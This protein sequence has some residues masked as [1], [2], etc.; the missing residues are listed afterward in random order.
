LLANFVA[1]RAVKDQMEDSSVISTPVDTEPEPKVV[2]VPKAKDA[3]PKPSP[4]SLKKRVEKE[5]FAA[6]F[7]ANQVVIDFFADTE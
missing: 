2:D 3:Q 7:D 5:S 4:A 1:R 6:W